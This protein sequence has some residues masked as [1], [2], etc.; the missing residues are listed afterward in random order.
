MSKYGNWERAIAGVRD[1]LGVRCLQD[2][3]FGYEIREKNR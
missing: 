1:L 3:H 2:R